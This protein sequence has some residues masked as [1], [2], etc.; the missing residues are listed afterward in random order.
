MWSS[1]CPP[2]R[3]TLSQLLSAP[4]WL[5]P[6]QATRYR[7]P[8]L[9]TRQ[10]PNAWR[11]TSKQCRHLVHPALTSVMRKDSTEPVKP[12]CGTPPPTTRTSSPPATHCGATRGSGRSGRGSQH[13]SS[14]RRLQRSHERVGSPF[15]PKRPPMTSST[16]C[17]TATP[18]A[19]RPRAVSGKA[20]L[21]QDPGPAAKASTVLRR[22]WTSVFSPPTARTAL[23]KVAKPPPRRLFS[24]GGTVRQAGQG[25]QVSSMSTATTSSTE[26]GRETPPSTKSMPGTG[27]SWRRKRGTMPVRTPS[28][29][30]ALRAPL[31]P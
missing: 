29:M 22:S 3:G 20:S 5:C 28:G 23:L 4:E 16:S 8:F 21:R 25:L 30:A 15:C 13:G 17:T 18:A 11:G 14:A 2:S 7:R 19:E 24:S 6:P 9:A 26:F 10:Q 12:T 27:R 31:G 1:C